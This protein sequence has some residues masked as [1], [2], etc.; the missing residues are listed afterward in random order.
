MKAKRFD[1]RIIIQERT[2]TKVKGVQTEDW[3]DFHACWCSISSL[4]GQE[5]YKAIE[6]NLENVLSFTVRYASNLKDL[7]TKEY[8]VMWGSRIF[9]LIATDYYGFDKRTITIKGKEVV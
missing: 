8:R 1:Q 5:V 3:S 6:V 4:Y 9:N 7:N 2:L